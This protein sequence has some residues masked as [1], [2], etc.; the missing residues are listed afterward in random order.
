MA[1]SMCKP[2]QKERIFIGANWT[3]CIYFM[4]IWENLVV[5]FLFFSLSFYVV[6]YIV[7][8]KSLV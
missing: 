8:R 1:P 3:S 6:D 5:G 4:F 7:F 2:M